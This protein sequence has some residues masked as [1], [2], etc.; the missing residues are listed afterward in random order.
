[1]AGKLIEPAELIYFTGKYSVTSAH[2]VSLASGGRADFA[3]IY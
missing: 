2:V 3:A 1:L